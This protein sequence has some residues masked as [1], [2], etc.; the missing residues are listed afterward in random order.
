MKAKGKNS[1]PFLRGKRA[2]YYCWIEGNLR[3]LGTDKP[4]V[5]RRKYQEMLTDWREAR[6]RERSASAPPPPTVR[7]CLDAYLEASKGLKGCGHPNRVKAF[8]DFCTA[9][10]AAPLPWDRL[11]VDLVEAWV[12]T[13]PDWSPSTRRTKVNHLVA[14]FNFCVRR[15]RIGENPIKG[16]ERPPFRRRKEM[17]GTVDEKT[18]LDAARGP[19]RSILLAL[20]DTGARPSELCKATVKDYRDGRIVLLEH[21][22]DAHVEERIIYLSAAVKADVERLIGDRKDG[23][24][25]RNARGRAWSPGVLYLRFWRFRRKNPGMGDGVFPYAFRHRF[26][27]DAINESDANPAMVARLLGHADMTMLMRHYFRENPEAAA[28]AL[29]EIRKGK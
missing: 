20:R 13:H 6:E 18:L 3:S 11:S 19:F 9:T 23:P 7:Q 10:G 15:K 22:E 16:I 27:S 17:I 2:R 24:I 12:D 5:A 1:G 25:W 26:A 4:Q 8:E 29:E 21:K 28:K 14:A